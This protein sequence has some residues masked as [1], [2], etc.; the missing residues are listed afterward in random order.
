MGKSHPLRNAQYLLGK[1]RILLPTRN[2]KGVALIMVL[3]ILAVLSVIAF[4]FSY[5]MRT[6][7]KIVGNDQEELQLYGLA[8]GGV[9]RAIAELVYK[10]DSRVQNKRRVLK[11]EELP[12]SIL[13]PHRI[14]R[15][16]A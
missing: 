14:I 4:E 11:S 9:Q 16:A 7:V 6:E 12:F 5:A 3:W 2:R 1:K 8:A 10:H 15:P 13:P